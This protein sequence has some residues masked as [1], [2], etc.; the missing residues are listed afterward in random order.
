MYRKLLLI[1]VAGTLIGTAGARTLEVV[2]GSY[3]AVLADVTLPGGIAGTLIVKMCS[4]CESTS[5]RVDSGTVYVGADGKQKPL[6]DFLTDADLLRDTA[7]GERTTGVGVFY[8]LETGRVTR[9]R[10]YANSVN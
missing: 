9:V 7:G 1:A 10:L 3:E 8:E 6:A 5:L 2:E 4:T